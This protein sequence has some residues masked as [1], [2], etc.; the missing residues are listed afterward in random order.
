MSVIGNN[1]A[2]AGTTGFK[3]SRAE[4]Q[5]ILSVSVKGIGSKAQVGSGS[6]L[7]NVK[8]LHNQGDV[9]RTDSNTD[10]AINGE[11]FFVV[12]SPMGRT[13][14]RDGSFRFNKL[15]EL[16]TGDGHKV[17]GHSF[18]DGKKVNTLESINLASTNVPAK[19]TS[20][21]DVK[22][23]L[24]SRVKPLVFDVSRPDQTS[25]FSSSLMVYDSVGVQRLVTLYFNKNEQNNW[26]YHVMADGADAEPT[27]PGE[28][29]EM[30][31]GKLIFDD[32]GYLKEEQEVSNSFNFNNGAMPDQKIQ[33]DFGT[34]LAEGG[35]GVQAATQFGIDSNVSSHSQD[36][37]SVGN[38]SSL[39]FDDKGIMLAAYDNGMVRNV[40]Q[41]ALARFENKQGLFKL[42]RNLY[43]QTNQSG[44]AAIGAPE[45][46]GRGEILS[47]SLELSNVDLAKEFV[48]LM[49]A[50]RNFKANSKVIKTANEMTQEVL[51]LKR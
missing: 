4:F 43:R 26:E 45:E 35:D 3:A 12:Q 16:V 32:K 47:R 8:V 39:S 21:V 10:L 44:Q 22:I 17:L 46:G 29:V 11:G 51:G 48:N 23:N 30:A 2:N 42:G 27:K 1:I 31:S 24:D 40:A 34:S 49:A 19:E 13:F 18:R 41:V 5:D 25:H 33:F 37:H 20:K 38:L 7:A 50:S 6:K 9:T 36:G 14:T 28:L 15:G